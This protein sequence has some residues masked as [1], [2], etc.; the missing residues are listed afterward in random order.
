MPGVNS[1][2]IFSNP[3]IIPFLIIILLFSGSLLGCWK[4]AKKNQ[5]LI[6]D[7]RDKDQVIAQQNER[8]Y[9]LKDK[10][11][12]YDREHEKSKTLAVDLERNKA[13]YEAELQALTKAKE[14]LSQA[15]QALSS[16]A[17]ERNN[18]SFLKLAESTLSRFHEMSKGHLDQKEKS[19]Q[20]LVSPLKESLGLV[21]QKLNHLEKERESAYSVLRH[22]VSELVTSQKELRQETGNLAKALRAPH[23][24]GRWGE[25]QL[26]RVVEMSGMSA[27]CDFIE[28]ATMTEGTSLLRPDMIVRLPG[29]KC[30]VIDAKAP[31]SSYLQALEATSE[32][33]R[34]EHL[35]AHARQVR[36]HITQL[37]SRSYWQNIETEDTPEFVVLFLPGET[38]FSAALEQ[39]PSLIEQGIEKKV[40]LATPATL[41][42]LLHAV[43]YGWRQEGLADNAREISSLGKE[44]Y[45]RVGD[46]TSHFTRLGQD[47]NRSTR[48]YNQAIGSL[49]SRVLPTVRRFRDLKAVAEDAPLASPSPVETVTRLP[50]VSE[51]AETMNKEP[52]QE[53]KH[54]LKSD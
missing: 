47:L 1:I 21:D 15:F 44:L 31:L 35:K 52:S 41:I 28:Q 50:H 42:A 14:D 2:Y 19:I 30:L 40:I 3:F 22:Q 49:E 46:M 32:A 20:Q 36:A 10:A 11:D 12:Q 16:Q 26:K 54:L 33:T 51:K 25:M 48:S 9:F 43:A 34:K 45:K 38:F 18:H 29:K 23:I 7:C 37:S 53:D 24:R 27:H 8:L 39:D 13:S 5:D 17:L 4:L 6:S